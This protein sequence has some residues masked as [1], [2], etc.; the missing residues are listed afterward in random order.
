MKTKAM[1]LPLICALGLFLKTDESQAQQPGTTEP[2]APSTKQE[3]VV[4]DQQ[5][6]LLRKDLRSRKKQLIAANLSLTSAEAENFWPVYG[7]YT[8][9]TIKIN[10][11]KYALIKKYAEDWG[12]MTDQQA[13]DYVRRMVGV[14]QSTSELRLK[15]WPRFRQV[16]SARNTA[17]F[18]QMDRRINIMIDLQL[19]AQIPLIEP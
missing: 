11:T 2:V 10:D 15:Y 17:L 12:H 1:V 8:A 18:F 5:I 4:S 9:E 19:S 16:V 13:E 3:A 6:A 14:D 7:E